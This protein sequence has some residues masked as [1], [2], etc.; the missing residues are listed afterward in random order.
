M[1]QGTLWEVYEISN[2]DEFKVF[3][4]HGKKPIEESG[5]SFFISINEMNKM[6]EEIN[7]R[8]Q[9]NFSEV[10]CDVHIVI[11]E[12]SAGS[13]RVALKRPKKV[14]GFPDS[15]SIGPLWRLNEKIGQSFRNQWLFEN[16]NDELNDYEYEEKFKYTLWEVEN[17]P[18]YIPIYLWHGNN[19]EEQV[20]LRFILYLLKDKNNKIYL[21][22]STE[23]YEMVASNKIKE[24]PIF[25]TGQIEPD[26][27]R[28]IFEKAA[29]NNPLKEEERILFHKQWKSLSQNKEVLRLLIEGEIRAV[30]ENYFDSMILET[31][32]NLHKKQDNKEF[33]KTGDVI[34]EIITRMDGIVNLYFLEYRIRY[35]IYSGALQLKGIPKTIN[36]YHVKLPD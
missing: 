4:H 10:E 11:S 22:N 5:S 20:G 7:S 24:E 25:H 36:H 16:I 13:L 8:I 14:I 3:N 2:I 9:C 35:L 6:K 17:I 33:V 23:T 27:L 31:I 29:K 26:Y 32:D 21:I 19:T 28:L 1:T 34:G 15:F 12:L 30:P 18:E